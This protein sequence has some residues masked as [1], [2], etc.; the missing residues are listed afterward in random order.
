[1]ANMFRRLAL[2]HEMLPRTTGESPA[3]ERARLARQRPT[4][5][6]PTSPGAPA[7]R[8][9]PERAVTAPDALVLTS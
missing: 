2:A 5:P 7:S 8:P 4:P 3:D 1:M 9:R 6:T